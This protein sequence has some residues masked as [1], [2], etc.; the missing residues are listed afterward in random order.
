LL[1]Q[2]RV[3]LFAI[4]EAHCIS[5]WGHDFRPAFMELTRVLEELGH[6][7]VLALTATATPEVIDDIVRSLGMRNAVVVNTGMFRPNLELG[8]LQAS[9]DPQKR[10]R[11]IQL[12][13]GLKGSGIVYAATLKQVAAVDAELRAAGLS[14]APY[15]GRMNPTERRENQDRFMAG[16]LKAIVATNAFGMGIDKPDIRFVVH[17]AMPGSLEAYYQEAGRAGRDGE[18]AKCTLL[19]DIHDRR[20]HKY[21]IASR[22]R[23]VITRLKRKG[24]ENADLAARLCEEDKRRDEDEDKLERMILYAQSAICRWRTLLEYFDA[25]DLEPSF[26]CGTCD[27]CLHAEEWQAR[28]G[29]HLPSIAS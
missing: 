11:L 12:L 13:Y 10:L 3:A 8:V 5:Q 19:F 4:D 6:P 26:R 20:T 21:F 22:H 9:S 7:P 29:E 1:G 16:E 27:A 18:P 23:G 15:H 24:L 14:C 28:P 2:C 17:Y 25:P